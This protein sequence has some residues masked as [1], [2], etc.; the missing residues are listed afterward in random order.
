[1]IGLITVEE[2]TMA[3]K[4]K[5]PM[6]RSAKKTASRAGRAKGRS[7]KAGSAGRSAARKKSAPKRK[8]AAK[9][10]TAKKKSAVKRSRTPGQAK[11]LTSERDE[12]MRGPGRL[13][14]T[15]RGPMREHVNDLEMGEDMDD[16]LRGDMSL[17]DE[18]TDSEFLDKPDDLAHDEETE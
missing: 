17:E 16:D 5:K 7:K 11:K 8:T 13:E 14:G 15:E 12:E 4:K 9:K 6:K 18:E 10:T 2:G 1:M 3:T